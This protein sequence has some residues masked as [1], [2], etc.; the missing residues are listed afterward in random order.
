MTLA[1]FIMLHI[2]FLKAIS[3]KKAKNAKPRWN[4]HCKYTF[5]VVCTFLT[6]HFYRDKLIKLFYFL[7]LVTVFRSFPI[8]SYF[9]KNNSSIHLNL[10]VLAMR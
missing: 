9:L 3:F 4:M 2:C 5:P 8:Q 7:A 10:C 1:V 6:L